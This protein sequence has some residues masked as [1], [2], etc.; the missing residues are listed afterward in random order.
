MRRG[1]GGEGK[2]VR[3]G[4]ARTAAC[5]VKLAHPDRFWITGFEAGFDL[6]Q[7]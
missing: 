7:S 4:G 3:G 6:N 2:G 1:E 5:W